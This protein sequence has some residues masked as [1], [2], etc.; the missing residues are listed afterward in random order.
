MRANRIDS[1]S[2]SKLTWDL[3]VLGGGTSGIVA[4]KTAVGL[5]ASVVLIEAER[6][7]GDCLWTGC[8]PSKALLAAAKKTHEVRTAKKLGVYIAGMAVDFPEVMR[9]VHN[10]IAAVGEVDSVDALNAAGVPVMN[11][12][13]TFMNNHTLRVNDVNVAFS[14]A[15][16]ATGAGPIV[17]QIPGLQSAKFLTSDSIWNL[18]E[19]PR[20]LLV[21]G[22]GSIG[23]ELGQ[24][25]VRLG[26]EVTLIEAA[27]RLIPC[28]DPYASII[29]ERSL[30]RDGM[31]IHTGTKVDRIS[32]LSDG[33][34][35]VTATRFD[36]T[37]FAV[38]YDYILL[39]IG[40]APNVAN[41]NLENVNVERDRNGFLAVDNRLRTTNRRIYAA[42]DVTGYPQFTHVAGVHGSLAATNA[43]LGLSRRVR[44]HSIPRI[45]FTDPEVASVGVNTGNGEG[46]PFVKYVTREHSLVDRAIVDHDLDG[47]SRIALNSKGRII[48]GTIVGPRAGESIAEITLAVQMRLRSRDL[49]STIHAYPTYGD[50]PWHAAI[51]DVVRHLGR[52]NSR[53][54]ISLIKFINRNR[55]RDLFS[56]QNAWRG[57]KRQD[58]EGLKK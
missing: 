42:G 46:S 22:G 1:A 34:G 4:A 30:T 43:V 23:C 45:T 10:S 31:N 13:G 37:E 47:F 15:I 25:F 6:L 41:L 52:P 44:T 7:G 8:V 51:S 50:G 57:K 5:G 56:M 39:T 48:G 33:T 17:P 12:Y 36:G 9:Q 35:F 20:K 21:I 3:A 49:A 53:R 27:P 14:Y 24:A 18:E 58:S 2:T 54:A 16:I 55:L 11:G 28:E 32:A 40:R 38:Q 19:L 26:S 29:V